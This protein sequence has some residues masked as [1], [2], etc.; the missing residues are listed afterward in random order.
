MSQIRRFGITAVF[1]ATLAGGMFMASPADASGLD[2]G[3]VC[4]VLAEKVT[5][6]QGLANQYPNNRVI[7][8]LLRIGQDAYAKYCS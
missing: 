7:A 1:V 2:R 3:R 8:F 6:L 4:S 5:Y